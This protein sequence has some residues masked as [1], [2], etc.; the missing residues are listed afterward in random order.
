MSE[1]ILSKGLVPNAAVGDTVTFRNNY[2]VRIVDHHDS[3]HWRCETW[4]LGEYY[5]HPVRAFIIR[6]QCKLFPGRWRWW[7]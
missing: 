7:L 5:W 1:I 3:D 2:R 6:V 4:S